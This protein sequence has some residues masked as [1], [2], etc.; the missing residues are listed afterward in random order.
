MIISIE[1]S[2]VHLQD[3]GIQI[4]LLAD[5]YSRTLSELCASDKLKKNISSWLI[6]ADP[7]PLSRQQLLRVHDESYVDALLADNPLT[8]MGEVFEFMNADGTL[9]ER[10]LEHPTNRPMNEL[11][12][13]RLAHAAGTVMACEIAISK[14]FSYFLGGGAHHAMRSG[15][16][17]FCMVNDLMIAVRDLQSR[18]LINRVW[19]IDLD[20][21]KG[22][23]TAELTQGDDSV[24]TM[25]IHM[26]NGWPLDESPVDGEGHLKRSFW[27][28]TVDVP[29][30]RGAESSYLDLLRHGL[31][32][33]EICSAGQRPDLAIVVDGSDPYEKDVLESAKCL[34]LS[35]EQCITRT[36][37]VHDW[38]RERHI[39]QAYVM[40]GGYGPD[41]WRVHAGFLQQ[42]LPQWVMNDSGDVNCSSAGTPS[43]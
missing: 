6:T 29:V 7:R 22:D 31:F 38:L 33:L 11:V 24:L 14:S 8:V 43:L 39:P 35:L 40:A 21:H 34:K 27:P 3:Y 23:G 36:T 10:F 37:F 1:N 16:R 28:S 25:S 9:N 30:P 13:K 42:V 4:P 2:N 17:G 20:A 5:R 15:G 18:K 26:Q 41:N 32:Q 12:Q 19:I